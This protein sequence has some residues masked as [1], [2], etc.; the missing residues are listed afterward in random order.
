VRVDLRLSN[1]A[2]TMRIERLIRFE[3]PLSDEQR[4][5]LL[6][7]ADKTPVTRALMAG[8]T[9]ETRLT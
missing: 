2:S 9:I 6:E 3:A 4:A 5:R 8:F 1:D 7:I